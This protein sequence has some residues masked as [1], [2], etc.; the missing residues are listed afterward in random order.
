MFSLAVNGMVCNVRSIAYPL[1]KD[2]ARI[3]KKTKLREL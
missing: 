3:W 2:K 1:P